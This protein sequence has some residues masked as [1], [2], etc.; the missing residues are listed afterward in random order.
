[1]KGGVRGAPTQQGGTFYIQSHLEGTARVQEVGWRRRVFKVRFSL[2]VSPQGPG[3][4][5][6]EKIV[7]KGK[8]SVLS[9]T[10]LQ[11]LAPSGP[12]SVTP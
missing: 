8:F 12:M 1:M 7:S 5:G 11:L 4:V 6:G 9:R 2:K 3:L 10:I